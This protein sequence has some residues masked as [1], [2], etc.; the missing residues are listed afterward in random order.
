MVLDAIGGGRHAQSGEAQSVAESLSMV[1]TNGHLIYS[2]LALA[3]LVPAAWLPLRATTGPGDDATLT[4]RRLA[5]AFRGALAVAVAGPL[6]WT[7]A[8]TGGT[9]H[10]G[11]S[12]ALWVTV[13]VSVVAFAIVAAITR[14]GWRLAPLLMPY[15]LLLGLLAT[16]WTRSGGEIVAGTPRIWV[17]AHIAAAVVTYALLTLAAIAGLS[18]LLQERALKNKH[19]T[20]LTRSLPSVADSESLQIRLL[21]TSAVVL[22]IGLVTGMAME[23]LERGVLLVFDHKIL[24]S[25]LSFAVICALL[26]AHYRTGMR[27]RRAARLVLLA[28]LLLTLGYPGVKFVTDVL[29]A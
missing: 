24:L 16:I 7:A 17:G 25:L 12:L 15:L 2:L 27:G 9:W 1:A 5:P 19:P 4:R 28:Y 6:I 14:E 23:W 20:R 22:G 10:T 3:A 29:L 11:F 21:A 26:L 8:Q 13:A 18:V